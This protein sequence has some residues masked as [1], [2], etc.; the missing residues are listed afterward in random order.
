MGTMNGSEKV[1]QFLKIDFDFET[2]RFICLI[3][4]NQ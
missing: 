1:E 3:I 2:V 4:I